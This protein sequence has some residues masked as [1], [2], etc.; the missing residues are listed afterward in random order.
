MIWHPLHQP[1]SET[2]GAV[3]RIYPIYA[4]IQGIKPAWFAKKMRTLLHPDETPGAVRIDL[5]EM[6]GT[7]LPE[8]LLDDQ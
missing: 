4:E 7:Q 2:G 5:D 1:A 3:G 8:Q 6:F